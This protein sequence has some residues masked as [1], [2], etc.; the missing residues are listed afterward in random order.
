[1]PVSS[2]MVPVG[3]PAPGFSLP[4]ADR[5]TVAFDDFAGRPAVLVAFVSDHCPFVR[6]LESALGEFARER[7]WLP[8]VAVCS[9]DPAVSPGDT[10]GE[11]RAQ[12][13]RAKWCFP[14]LIDADQSVARS[15]RAACTPDFFLYD[16]RR[17]LAYRG[18]FDD[19]TPGNGRPVTG[20]RLAEA[21]ELV[22]TGRPVPEP[23]HPSIGCSI[24]WT[25]GNEPE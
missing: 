24:K 20:A 2:L 19:S 8:V 16:S 3:T 18:S 22:R 12:A 25:P 1:M 9:N 6:H 7:P 14:Y 11:L 5:G 4:S 15:H 21:A 10:P 23:H 13:A 17:L